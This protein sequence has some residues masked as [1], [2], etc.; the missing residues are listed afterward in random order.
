MTIKTMMGEKMDF[1]IVQDEKGRLIRIK[2]NFLYAMSQAAKGLDDDECY[3][4]CVA[5][6]QAFDD[7][8][9]AEWQELCSQ[10]GVHDDLPKSI[11]L[12]RWLHE[13]RQKDGEA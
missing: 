12:K 6:E 3:G 2:E 7:L 11:Y 1:D 5:A 13:C 9:A 8:I 10:D 4:A